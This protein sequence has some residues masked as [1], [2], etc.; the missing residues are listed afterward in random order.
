MSRY[1]CEAVAKIQIADL[2]RTLTVFLG[3]VSGHPSPRLCLRQLEFCLM[4]LQICFSF[5]VLHKTSFTVCALVG[6]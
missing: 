1:T 4:F 3:N 2:S 5:H 6:Q